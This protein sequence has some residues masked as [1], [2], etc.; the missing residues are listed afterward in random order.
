MSNKKSIQEVL[1]EIQQNLKVPKGQK[2]SFGGYKYRS[3]EDIM[4]AVKKVLPTGYSIIASDEMIMLDD[5]FYVKATVTLLT[6]GE[7]VSTHGFARE[8]ETKKGMD[9]SQITGTASSYA[10]KYAAN[11]L[12]AIDDTKDADTDTFTKR[13]KGSATTNTKGGNQNLEFGNLM[14]NLQECKNLDDLTQWR[15]KYKGYRKSLPEGEE[16][17]EEFKK[18]KTKLKETN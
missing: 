15:L 11:G 18:L 2:N 8:A 10:R 17:F 9:D 5:R 13:M 12:F 6:S 7:S 4:E 16:L 3:C 14:S 1:A